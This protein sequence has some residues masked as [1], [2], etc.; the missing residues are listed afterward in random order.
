MR[1]MGTFCGQTGSGKS[2]MAAA[3]TDVVT[4]PEDQLRTKFSRQ[5]LY[6]IGTPQYN[7][8][9]CNSLRSHP[10]WEIQQGG[11]QNGSN[12]YHNIVLTLTQ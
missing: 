1:Q 4:Q 11:R 2:N 8:T 5:N 9:K 7:C 6:T 3:K 10:K 12:K